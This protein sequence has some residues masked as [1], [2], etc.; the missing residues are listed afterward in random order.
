MKAGLSL[1]SQINHIGSAA[2][3]FVSMISLN[4]TTTI[5]NPD[6]VAG[7]YAHKNQTRAKINKN[8]SY[9]ILKQKINS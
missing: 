3:S 1:K 9:V 6:M 7:R 5:S 4:V 2:H 8:N